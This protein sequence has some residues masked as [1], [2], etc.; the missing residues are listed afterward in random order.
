MEQRGRELDSWDALFQKAIDSLQPPSILR[1]MD[2]HC[3]RDSDP[4]LVYSELLRQALCLFRIGSVQVPTLLAVRE[5]Q[6]LRQES[7]EEEDETTLPAR[8]ART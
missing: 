3:S 6:D 8:P 1:K 7:L 4:S 5:W 2:Q